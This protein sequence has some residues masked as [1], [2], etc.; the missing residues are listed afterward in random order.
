MPKEPNN[1]RKCHICGVDIGRGKFCG[2]ECVE[3]ARTKYVGESWKEFWK[4][5][6]K[7]QSVVMHRVDMRAI[8]EKADLIEKLHG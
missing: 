3:Y 1:N 7:A 4:R 6:H 8:A 5:K 2:Q